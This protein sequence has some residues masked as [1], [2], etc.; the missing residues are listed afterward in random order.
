MRHKVTLG[1]VHKGS[2]AFI[3]AEHFVNKEKSIL[4]IARD[5]R[6]IYALQSKLFWLLPK[7]DILIFRSWDQIPYDS[8][9]PSREIQSERIKTLYQLSVNKQ[10]KIILSSVNAII[11]RTVDQSFIKKNYVTI[12][13]NQKLNF[14]HFIQQLISLGYQRT[15]VVREKTDFA[16]RGSIVDIFIVDRKNPLRIDFFDNNIE[17]IYEFDRLTQKRLLK[18]ENEKIY[19]HPSSELLINDETITL[20]RK[21]FREI[22]S[23]YR[24]S[25]V[26][27]SFSESILP[28]GGEQFLPFFLE[29]MET[30]FNFVNDCQVIVNSQFNDLLENRIEN[31]NDFFKARKQLN[32]NFY[33]KPDQLYLSSN[34]TNH[35]LSKSDLIK[36]SEFTDEKSKK[37]N[38]KKIPNL[39]SIRKEIDFD[40]IDK[41]FNIHSKL[42]TIIICCRSL[43]SLDRVHK[44]IY[45]NLNISLNHIKNFQEIKENINFYIT[46]LEIDDAF[47][48]G[49]LIFLNEKSLFGYNFATKEKSIK[50]KNIF[51]EEINKLTKESVLVHSDY[52]LCRFLD[53][54]KIGINSSF[55]DCVEL[56]FADNQKLFLPVENLNYIT[57]YSNDEDHNVLLDKLGHSHWQKRKAEAKN[58]IKDAAKK[59]IAIAAKRFQSQSYSIQFE[60]ADYDKF[61]S[62]FPFIETDDQLS[63]IEDVINDFKKDIPADRLIVGD[64]A[65]GKTEVIIRAI[66]LAARS[67][68]Q[69]I[70]LVPTTLLSRQHFENFTKR[71]MPFGI[72]VSQISRFVPD[73][74][75]FEIYDSIKNGSTQVIVGT[76]ALL[77]DKIFFKKL[78]LII[79]DE[80]QKFGTQQKEKLKEIAPRAHVISLSAT[81]IPRTLSMSLSGIRDLSLILT[82][83]YERLSVRTFV[84]PFDEFTIIEAIKREI[85]GRKNGVFFVTPRKKNIPFLEKFMQEKLPNIKYVVAHGQLSPKILESRISKFYNQEIPLLIST[86]IIEN[87]LDLPHVNTIVV[88]R[89]NMFS[90]SGIYQLKGRVGRSSKRGY[91]YLTYNENELTDNSKKRLSLI[92][93][94][95]QL[96][97]GFNVASQ[98]LEMRGGGSI[99]GE[100]Q[101]GFIREIGAELYHQM[102]EEEILKQ[103]QKI[104][105]EKFITKKNS[106]QPTIKIP[107]EIFISEKYIDDLDLRM[108]IYKRISSIERKEDSDQLMIELVDRFGLLPKPV[109]NLFK[110]I[111]LKILCWN[112][113]IDLV[114]FGRKGIV[115]GFHNN[116]P[117]NPGKILKLG[118]SHNKQ[119]IIRPDQKIFYDFFGQLNEDRFELI[120]KIIN[121]IN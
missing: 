71:F 41:F 40:F 98:D 52:G 7:A 31:I 27:N 113:N 97:S 56:E 68:L 12:F 36:F 89:S 96:G 16:I 86:N 46:T 93:S 47:E 28:P 38:I 43:G 79:Y 19:I 57:K 108:S 67:N 17:S 61:V 20:F 111:E 3:I 4:Y 92:N 119:I 15:S 11:Q 65:F 37:A 99:I 120:K 84:S 106:Y 83:P 14:N 72:K 105:V 90:L 21:N 58:K 22:F 42:K 81:P 69:S 6:E 82:A 78:G 30:F 102:L 85:I 24:L 45:E 48:L 2:E 49:K 33:L 73:K 55:H 75:K 118:F 76:H 74:E 51:F 66:Y 25:Q 94:F 34:E 26:Y 101:S 62:T 87:G 8:V 44:I 100:E 91:A 29:K 5:D 13:V 80:E 95:D 32:D 35:Y 23:N 9:S 107:E 88:H 116:E 1:S 104:S 60:A 109:F 121:N 114:E 18:I 64:V 103:K 54:K 110:L 10:K 63:A 39:S 53:I 77:S 117:P 70:V 59:L 112:N 115:L 50:N